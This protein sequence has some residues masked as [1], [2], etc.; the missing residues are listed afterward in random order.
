MP[1]KNESVLDRLVRLILAEVFL[2]SSFFWTWGVLTIVLA[3]LGIVMLV[4]SITGF[5]A[6]YKLFGI[7]T[8][9]KMKSINKWTVISM[10]V[11]AIVVLSGGVYGSHFFTKKFFLEDYNKMNNF[12]KQTLF[13][14]GQEKRDEAILN[15]DKLVEEYGVFQTKYSQY[16]PYVIR[17]DANFNSDLE[18][19][20]A[21]IDGLKETVYTG[22][23]P[24]A[25]KGLEDVRPVF[26]EML[27]R[28]NFSLLAV[29]L[30]DFHDAMEEILTP[31]DEKD[32]KKVI[33]VYSVV[34]GKLK[35]VEAIVNDEEIQAIRKN[36]DELKSLA[37]QN[38]TDD[39][40]TKGAE[41][42]S[43]FVKVYLK[44]G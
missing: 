14:T 13:L 34:D 44:R 35:D 8:L 36:L 12:Y 21:I 37:E 32:S 31:A 23:L 28:N 38:K 17:N 1:M 19:V 40:P 2:I 18:K 5:C 3:V 42:K 43:S 16:K 39:L 27:K 4:T 10:I 11:L 24:V 25:H 26:Q 7:N 33:D 15:Y 30:V 41:L 9:K 22:S 6:L 29:V 20:K